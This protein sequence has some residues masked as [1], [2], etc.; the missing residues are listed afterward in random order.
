MCGRARRHPGSGVR[1][2]SSASRRIASLAPLSSILL[3]ARPIGAGPSC[4]I[5]LRPGR[6]LGAPWGY[7]VTTVVVEPPPD[8]GGTVT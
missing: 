2:E 8:G 1:L 3:R 7:G 6:P 4:E 5:V